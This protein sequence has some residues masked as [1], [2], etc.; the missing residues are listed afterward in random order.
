MRVVVV[1]ITA[2]GLLA[3]GI[4]SGEEIMLRNV[5]VFDPSSGSMG[6][7]T[8]I[9]ISGDR[10]AA[11]G[12]ADRERGDAPQIDCSGK[13][14]LPGLFDCH[15][16]VAHLIGEGED[17]LRAGLKGF[18]TSGITQLRDV[19][20][21]IDMLADLSR[22]LAS[23]EIAGPE[24]FYTGPM[25]ESGPLTWAN[26][27]ESLPNFTVAIDTAADVDSLL[28]EL[29]RQGACM[30]KTFNTIDAELYRHVVAVAGQNGLKIVHDPGTPFFH[31]MPMDAAIDLGVTSIE[32]A[33]AP[34]P[35]VL[36]DDLRAEHD[37]LVGPDAN[38]MG[39]MAFVMKACELGVESVSRDRLEW[40][41]G[42]MREKG[43]CLCPTLHVL[44]S[45]EE[46]IIEN[47]KEQQKLDEVPDEMRAM[48]LKVTRAMDQVS[49]L[50]VR[51][52]AGGGVRLLVGQDGADPAATF[53]EMRLLEECGVSTAE[54][55]KGATVYPA[56]WLGVDDR[57]GSLSEGR[58]ANILVVDGNPLEDI[59]QAESTFLVVHQGRI[60]Y[61]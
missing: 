52:L 50:F 51:E 31:W 2:L 15:T 55:L 8:D 39:K 1:G 7:P 44:A 36:T 32:H 24:L 57:L 25:L 54:I 11:M 6:E 60:V 42:E 13:F 49:R 4:V 33:K 48:V 26:L 41:A 59:G 23:G 56:Q 35:V 53:A 45:S 3:G 12:K 43:A 14:A 17:S 37:K 61:R 19:G 27:N 16:H 20:G 18:L 9:F 5:R 58:Q 38:P 47:V 21:P 46:E 29:A 30:I 28:P 34:W 10:I 22:R 40:L